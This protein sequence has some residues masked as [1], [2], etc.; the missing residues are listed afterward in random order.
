MPKSEERDNSGREGLAAAPQG[1][2]VS[3]G[4]GNGG[5]AE[6]AVARVGDPVTVWP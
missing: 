3:G 1:G 5:S 2:A 6:T 4:S